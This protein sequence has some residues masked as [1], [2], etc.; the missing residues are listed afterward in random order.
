MTFIFSDMI[1]LAKMDIPGIYFRKEYSIT[2][3]AFSIQYREKKYKC[4]NA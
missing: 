4:F 2:V 1:S 3:E